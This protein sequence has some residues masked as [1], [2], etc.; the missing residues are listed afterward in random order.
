MEFYRQFISDLTDELYEC[1]HSQLSDRLVHVW[2]ILSVNSIGQ[3]RIFATELNATLTKSYKQMSE[4]TNAARAQWA[5]LTL[6]HFAQLTNEG[7]EDQEIV[8]TDLLADLM[9]LADLGDGLTLSFE[10]A[11]SRARQ[12]HAEERDRESAAK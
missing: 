8:L 7:E 1:T 9:H 4:P 6:E 5:A 3:I 12:H 2:N 11:L 10:R